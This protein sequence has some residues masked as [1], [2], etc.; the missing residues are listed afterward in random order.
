MKRPAADDPLWLGQYRVLA[1]LGD[2]EAG[3]TLLGSGPDGQPV[4]LTLFRRELGDN[5]GFRDRLRALPVP[6]E[7]PAAL[8]E[9]APD[10]ARPW[11]AAEFVPGRPLREIL[12]TTGPLP[13]PSVRRLA[14][15]LAA[16]LAELHRT[17]QA[18]GRLKPTNVLL[19]TDGAHLVGRALRPAAPADDILALGTVL[20]TASGDELPDPLHACLAG[21]PA[22]QP[23]AGQLVTAL[24]PADGRWPPE[25]DRLI[26]EH[27]AEL[28][29]Y[30]E[31]DAARQTTPAPVPD[32]A[33]QTAP[34]PGPDAATHPIADSVPARTKPAPAARPP[35]K[36]RLLLGAVALIL[37]AAGLVAWTSWPEPPRPDTAPTAPRD[38]LVETGFLTAAGPPKLVRFSPDGTRIAVADDKS[39]LRVW[40]LATGKRTGPD[41]G[42]FLNAGLLDLAFLPDGTVL[43]MA[44]QSWTYA[45][46]SWN[47]ATGEWAGEPL[48]IGRAGGHGNGPALSADGSLAAVPTA[49]PTQT[50]IWRLGDRTLLGT[51]ETPDFFRGAAFSPD[52]R[53]LA[54]YRRDSESET[55]IDLTVW[56][57]ATLRPAGPPITLTDSDE[58]H[59]YRFHPD[60]RTLLV[61]TSPPR[62]TSRRLQQWDIGT[63]APA[64]PAFPL[65]DGIQ[66]AQP[67]LA[68]A[69]PGTTDLLTVASKT[70]TIRDH[71]GN[72]IGADLPGI[73]SA[74]VSPD[75]KTIA[76][77]SAEHTDTTV[78]LWRKR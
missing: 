49:E 30:L 74:A 11:L 52:R 20:A 8:R 57:L 29:R 1:E 66:G 44:K 9:T 14:A 55:I 3:R 53:F 15:G 69:L 25:V 38:P 31:R 35:R 5:P 61:V 58:L 43:T 22:D 71:D 2:G 50:E 62:L 7:G 42:P 60:S 26:A 51:L 46:Q 73:A 45:F 10:A 65:T 4:A 16:E 78:H 48:K 75:G 21:N 76:T 63:G 70:L 77:V 33:R 17:G 32:A 59:G 68:T 37:V 13:A 23:T 40:D 34:A 41:I 24:G 27:A 67:A 64:R 72:P 56:D 19:N 6:G 47:P 18:H 28:D 12:D 39:V 54:G 36:K